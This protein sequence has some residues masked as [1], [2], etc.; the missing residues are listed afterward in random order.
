[1]SQRTHD[2]IVIGCGPYG[3]AAA[4]HLRGAGVDVHVLGS[5][6]SFWTT[7]MPKGMC[8]RSPWSASHI[9]EPKG[10]LSLHAFERVRGA[11][12][13]R[14]I[15][16]SDFIAYGHWF[17]QMAVPNV[18]ERHV[19]RLERL[20][21]GFR[22]R[23]GDGDVLE[24]RRLVVAAGISPFAARPAVFD[25]LPPDSASHSSDHADL[26]RFAG[27]RVAVIGGGQSAIESAALLHEGGAETE[28]IMRGRH[29]RWVGRA[30][31]EGVIGRF[32]FDRTDVGPA[33]L[34]HFVARPMWVRRT[35]ASVLRA[36]TRSALEPGGSLWLRKRMQDVLVTFG[37]HV[38]DATVSNRHVILRL[39]D[40][41]AREVDHVLLAT[42]YRVDIE[43]YRF[44]TPELLAQVRRVEGHPV[45]DTGFQSSVPGLHFIGAPA[46]HSFGPLVRFVSGTEFAA[47]ALVRATRD[48]VRDA[49]DL[50]DHTVEIQRAAQQVQ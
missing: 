6:M 24:C 3:L 23:L 26:T 44:L 42:G 41:S 28:L 10:P 17:R 45:L 9:G 22:V 31:R 2:V 50:A 13:R 39:D 21:G 34:S 29:I 7:Q 46:T 49:T 11:R 18:D 16:I 12:L 19:D 14:P 33:L 25:G 27:D 15:P 36:V 30:P 5:P 37:R 20:D 4:A 43:R 40:G 35:P 48:R 8:L 38:I 47:R 1:V 32:L